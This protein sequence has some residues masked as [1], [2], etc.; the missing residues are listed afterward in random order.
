M[1]EFIKSG[2]LSFIRYEAF[3]V[4]GIIMVIGTLIKLLG[5]YDF[6]SDWFW[7]L[8]GIGLVVE[9]G[10][11]LVKQRKFDRKYKIVDREEEKKKAA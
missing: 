11:S 2:V 10:I 5:F 9:G 3:I 1:A 4:V 8:A 7:F 6:S